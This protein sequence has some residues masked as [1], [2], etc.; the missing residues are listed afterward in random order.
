MGVQRGAKVG[1]DS[2][3]RSLDLTMILPPS[4]LLLL[5]L[6]LLA[7]LVTGTVPVFNDPATIRTAAPPVTPGSPGNRYQYPM[8]L[9]PSG[10]LFLLLLPPPGYF[11]DR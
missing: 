9:S 11:G 10:L 8:I 4:G 5:V 7:P 6:P 2:Q 1:L 3:L